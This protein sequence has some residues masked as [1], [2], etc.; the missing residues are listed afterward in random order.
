M[1]IFAIGHSNYPY[2]KLIN[3]I[4]KYDINC[5]VDIRETP[6]SK[7]NIQYNKEAFNESLRNSGFIYIYMGKEFG[8]KRTNKDVY[9][10]EGYADFEKVAK[11]DIF[12]NGIER[13]KKGC[14]MGYRIVLLGAMQEPIRCHRSILVGKVLNKEGFDVKYIMHEGNLAYQE[15]IEESLLD[16]YFSDRKQLS[17]DN[18]LG[19]ALTREEM[20]QEGYNLA[21]KEIGY[22]TEKLGK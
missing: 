21:N 11:E 13:L 22:R 14:Q 3:M 15:D 10:Q 17:I 5:V 16:K 18:L 6:Y 2:D 8:A 4:K 1:E 7:Y 19:S 20:I 9:T 12:L